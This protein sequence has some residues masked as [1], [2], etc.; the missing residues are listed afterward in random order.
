MVAHRLANPAG[1]SAVSHRQ[2][3]LPV[4]RDVPRQQRSAGKGKG[5]GLPPRSC[6]RGRAGVDPVALLRQQIPKLGMERKK[7]LP[8]VMKKN[9]RLGGLALPA[10]RASL[11]GLRSLGRL[12]H[13]LLRGLSSGECS[14]L[15]ECKSAPPTPA[16]LNWDALGFKGTTL[17]GGISVLP[18]L[19]G[20]S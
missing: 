15:S 10:S 2:L 6:S 14:F 11:G 18:T 3:S 8:V 12:L 13:P 4:G 16:M 20:P 5:L 19:G 1:T 17:G 7:N 9:L